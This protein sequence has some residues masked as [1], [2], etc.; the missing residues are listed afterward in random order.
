MTE[1]RKKGLKVGISDQRGNTHVRDCLTSD[2]QLKQRPHSQTR[3]MGSESFSRLLPCCLGAI[4]IIPNLSCNGSMIFLRRLWKVS[5]GCPRDGP[6]TPGQI[7]LA[8]NRS[9]SKARTDEK[10]RITRA[11]M[12][13]CRANYALANDWLSDDTCGAK[14]RKWPTAVA[15][16]TASS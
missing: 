8:L 4:R 2:K 10:M 9:Q 15:K 13:S 1:Q 6:I 5:S 7:V 3:I 16:A 12:K 14:R 11:Q